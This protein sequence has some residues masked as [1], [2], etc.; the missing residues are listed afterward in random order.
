MLISSPPPLTSRQVCIG[1]SSVGSCGSNSQPRCWQPKA[2]LPGHL[3]LSPLGLMETR[4]PSVP[5]NNSR[6]HSSPPWV[7]R[8]TSHSL[9]VAVPLHPE[10]NRN[11]ILTNIT[12]TYQPHQTFRFGPLLVHIAMDPVSPPS[13]PSRDPSSTAAPLINPPMDD[14]RAFGLPRRPLQKQSDVWTQ[15]DPTSPSSFDWANMT[16]LAYARKPA[17]EPRHRRG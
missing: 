16:L 3:C 4:A 14:A 1:P 2:P 11:L 8:A 9:A 10:R 12:G 7:S 13:P 5:L 6:F 17:F 15:P